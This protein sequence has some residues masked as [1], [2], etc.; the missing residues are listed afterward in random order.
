MK[1]IKE[2]IREITERF[3][4]HQ[5]NCLSTGEF[6][7]QPQAREICEGNACGQYG[8]TWSCPP[9]M[10]TYEE[11]KKLILSYDNAFVFTGKYDLEDSYDFEG[12]MEGKKQFQEMCRNIREF[13]RQRHGRC[14]L[15]GN[16]S[17]DLC[18][19]CTYPDAPCRRPGD[20]ITSLEGYG[21]MVNHLAESA[22]VNYINGQNTVTYF[23][24]VLS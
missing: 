19:R 5:W 7:F 14:V 23:A 24:V 1:T 22:G 10:G 6:D 13:W 16:G 4:I 9:A 20:M 2:T 8:K 3:P 18:S 15:L 21:V 12:M 11:C 17:C